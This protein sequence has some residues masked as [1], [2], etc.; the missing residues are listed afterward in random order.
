M[1][2]LQRMKKSVAQREK[3]QES[4]PFKKT[5][6]E[7]IREL[8]SGDCHQN[9]IRAR[10]HWFAGSDWRREELEQAIDKKVKLGANMQTIINDG[11][12]IDYA[13][14]ALDPTAPGYDYDSLDYN[15]EY[16]QLVR[17]ADAR[18]KTISKTSP[19]A[20]PEQLLE[21][22][23]SEMKAL[24]SDA[25]VKS[26]TELFLSVHKY[27]QEKEKENPE[28]TEGS[29]G[30][31]LDAPVLDIPFLDAPVFAPLEIDAPAPTQ[32]AITFD[33]PQTVEAAGVPCKPSVTEDLPESTPVSDSDDSSL[34]TS[35]EEIENNSQP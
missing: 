34:H 12:G 26:T 20:G 11:H 24:E 8:S 7:K 29:A 28:K 15:E 27:V 17:E 16:L 4:D 5:F 10:L 21:T 13:V 1:K 2:R 30:A 9:S 32:Q 23:G 6:L 18:S 33:P 25:K 19:Q 22:T 31:T 3:R 14:G 35:D